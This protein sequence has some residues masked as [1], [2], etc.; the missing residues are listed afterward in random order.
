MKAEIPGTYPEPT[1]RPA[2]EAARRGQ[3]LAAAR[4]CIGAKGYEATTIRDVAAAS[5]VSTGT[6][7]YYFP[8]KEALL[9][10]ALED[11]AGD[12]GRRL[13][14]AAQ[15][16]H[17]NAFASLAAIIEAS[18]PLP[19]EAP[20]NWHVWMEF[21]GQAVRHPVLSR[22]HAE[23]YRGWRR[24]IARVIGEGI[25]AGQFQPVDA[26]KTARQLAGLIDGLAIHSI[27]GDPEI[28]TAEV[29][30]LCVD[31]LQTVLQP[32]QGAAHAG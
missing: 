25:A 3:I 17:G 5:G 22:T 31:Y 27:V 32:R 13:R 16:T 4:A 10:A 6:I 15:Q 12:L 29:R 1:H 26:D 14:L 8:G 19:D 30:R 20:S 21:W 7:N 2:V 28:P 11:L 18:L 24:L 23:L 9:V